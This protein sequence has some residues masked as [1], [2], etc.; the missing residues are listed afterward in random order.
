MIQ[1]KDLTKVDLLL[2]RSAT[3]DHDVAGRR[4]DLPMP[5]GTEY[6]PP[7]SNLRSAI[8]DDPD[9]SL[10]RAIVPGRRY[11]ITRR[12]C[13]RRFFMRPDLL[14]DRHPIARW[15]LQLRVKLPPASRAL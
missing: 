6:L 7:A 4:P 14:R 3:D 10:P 9:M 11:M 15:S 12:C 2:V 8:A 13:E 1:E 5:I